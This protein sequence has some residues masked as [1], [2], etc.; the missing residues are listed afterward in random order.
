MTSNL[1]WA[2]AYPAKY[3]LFQRH[4]VDNFYNFFIQRLQTFSIY[5]TSLRF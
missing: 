5:V 3:K 1:S 2:Y 4:I